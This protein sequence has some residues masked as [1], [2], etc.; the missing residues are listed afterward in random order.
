LEDR[1]S[2]WFRVLSARYGT[3]EGRL[4][5][6]GHEASEWWRVVHSLSRENWFGDHVSRWVGNGRTTLFWSD[7]WSGRVSFRVRFSRLFELSVL[8]EESVLEMSQLGWGRVVRRGDGG[9]GCSCGRRRW[10]GNSFYCLLMLLCRSIRKINGFGLWRALTHSLF[11]VCIIF[12]LFSHRLGYQLMF[13]RFGI[14][15]CLSRW[16][17]LLDG[18]FGIDCLPRT[19]SSGEVLLIMILG[20]V[21]Q[22]V[23]LLNRLLI[24]FCTVI[25]LVQFDTWFIVGLVSQWPTLFMCLI[26]FISLAS[27]AG[28]GKSSDRFYRL[29]GMQLFGKSG[30]NVTT[31][32][33]K[34]KNVLFIR[35]LI[36][37]RPSPICGWRRNI[38]LFPSIFM[39]GGLIRSP[40]WA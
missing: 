24:Y 9:G 36:G 3:D 27:L 31:G 12:L 10:W 23:T 22:G 35:W 7:V 18:C 5:G 4:R 21:W 40:Y 8:K 17:C 19:I 30:R 38:L 33:L 34:A 14:R 26:I 13:L 15:M 29:Y 20:C 39:A 6:G 16:W 11:V 37:L 1:D 32:C 2:L 25:H 28:L